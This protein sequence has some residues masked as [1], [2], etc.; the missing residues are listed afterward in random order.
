MIATIATFLFSTTIGRSVLIGAAGLIGLWAFGIYKYKE[1][2]N[3]CKIEWNAAEAEAIKR[4]EEARRSGDLDAA[5]PTDRELLNDKDN[6][7]N[8]K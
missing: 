1:G 3:A 6:R 5:N 7:H 2:Y 4:A 8:D